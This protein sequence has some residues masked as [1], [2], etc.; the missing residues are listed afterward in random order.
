[1]VHVS[2]P[3]MKQRTDDEWELDVTEDVEVPGWFFVPAA[4]DEAQ[5]RQWLA[6]GVAALGPVIGVPGWD[7]Q[8]TTEAQV[9][10]VLQQAIDARAESD[11]LALFQVWPV[12]GAAAVMCRVAVVRSDTLP[13]PDDTDAVARPIGAPHVGPGVQ[14]ST[15]RTLGSGADQV[16]LSSLH[17][18]F[19]DGDVALALSLEES[20][21][22]LIAHA[23]PG[24]AI[25]KD[26]IR[27]RRVRDG[28]PFVSVAPQ[29]LTVD[30]SWDATGEMPSGE[31][32]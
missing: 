3:E 8:P 31:M 22:P 4:M 15:S 7:E 14:Y 6:E 28:A 26:V 17:L 30:E 19:D 2:E 20:V 18:V 1:M 9:R 21:A 11:A 5:A 27:M 29:G 32:R 10:E 16:V 23:T 13:G 12:V 24:L 25:L